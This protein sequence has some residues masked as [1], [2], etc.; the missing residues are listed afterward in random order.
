MDEYQHKPA[1]PRRRPRLTAAITSIALII[2][3]VVFY[4]SFQGNAIALPQPEPSYAEAPVVT[5]PFSA[6]DPDSYTPPADAPSAPAITTPL[7]ISI[8]SLSVL[9][10]IVETGADEKGSL[11]LPSSEKTTRYTGA[12]PIGATEG[13]TVIAGHVNF[14]D[15]SPGALA[16]IARVSKG[17]P[18]FVTD[19]T[20]IIHRYIV[21]SARTL[22]KTALPEELFAKTGSPQLV[23]ITCGG[24]IEDTGHGVL[25]YTHNTVITAVPVT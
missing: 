6:T 18:V 17:T 23:L 3:A 13:S 20:G 12:A 15:G 25:G 5:Q 1:T 19:S 16:P 11:I 2:G 14:P 4:L 9:A 24:R 22:T 21:N 8:P 10:P 7:M